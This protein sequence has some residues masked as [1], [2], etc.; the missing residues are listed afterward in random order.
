MTTPRPE[1]LTAEEIASLRTFVGPSHAD[2]PSGPI[3]WVPWT[4]WQRLL[5]TLDAART[6]A[7][8][9]RAAVSEMFTD[10]ITGK[11][12]SGW[13]CSNELADRLRAALGS[14]ASEPALDV[15]RLGQAM[16]ASDGVAWP[17]R[18]R[19][20][21]F[22]WIARQVAAEYARLSAPTDGGDAG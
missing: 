21:D 8:D 10:P 22:A 19:A 6:P 4:T 18:W 5:A 7:P 12:T 20:S 13:W 3:A 14:A 11:P 1:A 15:E 16:A 17:T 9:L 2:D